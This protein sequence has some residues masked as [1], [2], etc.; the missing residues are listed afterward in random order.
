MNRFLFLPLALI[1]SAIS[2]S[3]QTQA[4]MT[5]QAGIQAEFA[6]EALNSVYQ[7][8]LEKLH[9]EQA[10]ELFRAAQNA[11]VAFR[12]AEAAAMADEMR[13]G[14][15]YS[16]L[17]LGTQARLTKERIGQIAQRF[18][19][20]PVG[21]EVEG[22]AT[23]W[24]AAEIFFQAYRTGNRELAFMVAPIDVVAMFPF[25]P[26]ASQNETLELMDG[27]NF[28]YYEGGGMNLFIDEGRDG[29][30]RITG[31]DFVID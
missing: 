27:G 15:A 7:A 17:L 20:G 28:I 29:R 11:W 1:I 24:R 25:D 31:V 10:V 6:D 8:A 18:E 19:L 23:E 14:T 5:E 26:S 9:D 3:A 13:G 2:V 22:A 30:F 21:N 4:E 16:M 12:D